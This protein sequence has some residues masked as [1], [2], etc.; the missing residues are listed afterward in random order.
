M[1]LTDP[2]KHLVK[3]MNEGVISTFRLLM[4]SGTS[5]LNPELLKFY[6]EWLPCGVHQ[7]TGA[8]SLKAVPRL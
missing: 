2:V 1:H 3:E 6:D 5:L 7:Y 8:G 4:L